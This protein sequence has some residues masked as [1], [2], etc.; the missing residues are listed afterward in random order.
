MTVPWFRTN[1]MSTAP[2][3]ERHTNAHFPLPLACT[4]GHHGISAKAAK[5]NATQSQ[6]RKQHRRHPRDG[7]R[8]R[9]VAVNPANGVSR[10]STVA[11]NFSTGWATDSGSPCVF[12]IRVRFRALTDS[13]GH[14]DVRKRDFIE[15]TGTSPSETTPTIR[16]SAPGGAEGSG[17]GAPASER[18]GRQMLVDH[19]RAN[20]FS[21]VTL[22]EF[23]T[24]DQRDSHGLEI[25]RVMNPT[26]DAMLSP[27]RG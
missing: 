24:G 21:L 1:R 8:R 26:R 19:G 6:A 9:H 5:P 13:C 10:G 16:T 27:G 12:R 11:D 2:R 25:V 7:K 15:G 4:V 18:I 17:P 3:P 23:P 14:V 20:G 22:P